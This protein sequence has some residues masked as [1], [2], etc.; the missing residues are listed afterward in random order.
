ME[1]TKCARQLICT[2]GLSAGCRKALPKTTLWL[3]V[4]VGLCK[5]QDANQHVVSL[6]PFWRISGGIAGSEGSMDSNGQSWKV[7]N[8][9]L[10][11]EG[12]VFLSWV[13]V[14]YAQLELKILGDQAFFHPQATKPMQNKLGQELLG[15]M[16][17]N[18][19]TP[20]IHPGKQL[21][22]SLIS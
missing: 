19:P 21:W 6:S 18:E 20:K 14:W 4:F 8:L 5:M 17:L 9:R 22:P 13:A 10:L 7:S 2:R 11:R 12:L 15:S 16:Q 3:Y 1:F